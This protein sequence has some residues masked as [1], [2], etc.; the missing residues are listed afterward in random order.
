MEGVSGNSQMRTM[1]VLKERENR[2][3]GGG[4]NEGYNYVISAVVTWE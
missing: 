4:R 2:K 3:D 1:Q